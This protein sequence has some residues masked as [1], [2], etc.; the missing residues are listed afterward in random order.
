MRP[1]CHE[2]LYQL[3]YNSNEPVLTQVAS[4]LNELRGWRNDADYD[5]G[6][7][8]TENSKTAMRCVEIA[9]RATDQFDQYCQDPTRMA[10]AMD[11]VRR[12]A[13]DVLRLT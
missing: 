7:V 12:Y 2:K 4:D 3:L 5:L 8:Y 9:Q 11:N 6:D 1:D 10:Q 13:R